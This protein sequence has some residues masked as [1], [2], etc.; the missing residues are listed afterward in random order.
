MPIDSLSLSLKEVGSILLRESFAEVANI[1]RQTMGATMKHGN[2][3]CFD[4]FVIWGREHVGVKMRK[5][6]IIFEGVLWKIY[7]YNY[8]LLLSSLCCWTWRIVCDISHII[9]NNVSCEHCERDS[10]SNKRNWHLFMKNY[11]ASN[12]IS[13]VITCVKLYTP[14]S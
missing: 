12:H 14:Y 5:L 9:Y 11:A 7:R 1:Q 2:G 4:G 13:C 6:F 3:Y 8:M 10:F